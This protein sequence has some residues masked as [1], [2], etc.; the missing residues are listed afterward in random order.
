[1]TRQRTDEQRKEQ[2]R[3][4]ATRCFVRRGFAATRLLDIAREAGL[5]KGGVYFHYRAKEQIFQDIL[6]SFTRLLRERWDFEPAVDQPADRT[7]GRLVIAHV[8]TMV[9]GPDEVRLFNLLVAM[10]VQEPGF[11]DKL[12]EIFA[13]KRAIYARVIERGQAEGA[14]ISGDPQTLATSVLSY[15]NG[16]G[17]FAPLDAEGQLPVTP[18]HAAE[19]VLRMLKVHATASSVEFASATPKPQPN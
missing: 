5:S 13:I 14:F 16:L 10:A 12:E 18:E 8:R 3:V 2:I 17:A 4:A 9:D 19:Q 6:D 1:M 15:V 7:M 11:R